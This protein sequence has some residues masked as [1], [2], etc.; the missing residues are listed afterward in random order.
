MANEVINSYWN[1]DN[2]F[3]AFF[4]DV[5]KGHNLTV[6]REA[7]YHSDT[8]EVVVVDV[9]WDD[10]GCMTESHSINP[11]TLKYYEE[12]CE[13]QPTLTNAE[14]DELKAEVRRLAKVTL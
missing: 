9:F 11:S 6:A 13:I 14:Y 10:D 1:S 5:Y 7:E 2:C 8:D 3:I 4:G 12:N